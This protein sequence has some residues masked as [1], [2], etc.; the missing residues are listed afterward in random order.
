MKIGDK[1]YYIKHENVYEGIVDEQDQYSDIP[2]Y[3]VK[4]TNPVYR[5]I[6]TIRY[7]LW[8]YF[9][10]GSHQPWY[11]IGHSLNENDV[12]MNKEDA[13]LAASIQ[14]LHK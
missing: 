5:A 6:D 10:K 7:H 14:K 13:M 12:Y 2:Y 1:V 8:A 4:N 9:G 11:S 3:W